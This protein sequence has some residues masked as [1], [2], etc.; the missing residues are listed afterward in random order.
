MPLSPLYQ[1]SNFGE[2]VNAW[3]NRNTR[4]KKICVILLTPRK[5]GEHISTTAHVFRED[6]SLEYRK[7]NS[8]KFSCIKVTADVILELDL[9]SIQKSVMGALLTRYDTFLSSEKSLQR[10]SALSN[11][12]MVQMGTIYSFISSALHGSE[13]VLS[14]ATYTAEEKLGHLCIKMHSDFLR[15]SNC[16]CCSDCLCK[17]MKISPWITRMSLS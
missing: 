10:C 15:S 3:R 17:G 5:C 16:M 1:L 13:N 12:I 6:W 9:T 11:R 7:L 8:C 2:Q 4:N 14:D